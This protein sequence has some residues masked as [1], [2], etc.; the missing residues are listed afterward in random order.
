M[1]DH[2]IGLNTGHNLRRQFGDGDH[3]DCCLCGTQT[4]FWHEKKDVPLCLPCADGTPGH[5]VPTKRQWLTDLGFTLP[6]D[7]QPAIDE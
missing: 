3:E 6:K 7:W 4:P 5:L 1:S 2:N